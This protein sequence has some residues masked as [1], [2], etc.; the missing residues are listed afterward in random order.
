MAKQT[1]KPKPAAKPAPL[2]DLIEFF[3]EM[4]QGSPEWF[5]VRR[6]ILTASNF[7]VMMREGIDGEPSKTRDQLLRVIAGEILT[8]ETDEGFKSDAM[9]RGN[10]VEPEAFA[11][12]ARTNFD[13]SIERI[14]FIRRTIVTPLGHKIVVGASPDAKV[15]ARKGLEI[16]TM[17]A[18]LLIKQAKAATYP[19]K[20]RWQVIGTMLVADWDEMDGLMF[21]RGMPV[22]LKYPVQRNESDIQQLRN[23]IEE[24][25]YDLNLLLKD[26]RKMG[27]GNG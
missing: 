22:Q 12:Y 26:L 14:G 23:G 18:D 13:V 1:T 3:P 15:G 7:A 25:D 20:H 10:V 5:D 24:F 19:S 17:K 2:K 4:V 11:Y 27:G 21:C 8:G 16:K 9:R 6:G